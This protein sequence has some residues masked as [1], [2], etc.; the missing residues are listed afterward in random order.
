MGKKFVGKPALAVGAFAKDVQSRESV[1]GDTKYK[2]SI[3]EFRRGFSKP[4]E[5]NITMFSTV[6]EL[7]ARQKWSAPKGSYVTPEEEAVA[8]ALSLFSRHYGTKVSYPHKEDVGF[9]I[10]A[11]R[12]QHSAGRDFVVEKLEAIWKA[13]SLEGYKQHL[14]GIIDFAVAPNSAF[15]YEIFTQDLINLSRPE[16]KDAV[17]IKWMRQ[18]H[19]EAYSLKTKKEQD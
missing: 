18:F 11:A 6:S 15:D 9:G 17:L 12:I 10:A 5:E 13:N 7:L 16:K 4:L 19:N 1:S 14:K 2:A 3:S 8:A